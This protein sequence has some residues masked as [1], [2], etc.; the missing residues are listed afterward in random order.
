MARA[1]DSRLK[2]SVFESCVMVLNH[3]RVRSL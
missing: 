1:M 2:E 3:G